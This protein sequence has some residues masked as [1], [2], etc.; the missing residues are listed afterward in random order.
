MSNNVA[1]RNGRKLAL[2]I[3]D[4]EIAYLKAIRECH[5]G[6]KDAI[7]ILNAKEN[8]FLAKLDAIYQS[9]LKRIETS[10]ASLA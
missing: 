5:K 2:D 9:T 7:D 6:E 1:D 8:G 3:L 4:E 10:L